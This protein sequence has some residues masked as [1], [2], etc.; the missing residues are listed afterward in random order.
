MR[1]ARVCDALLRHRSAVIVGLALFVLAG[2]LGAM[3]LPVDMSFRPTFTGD[4]R[5]VQRTREHEQVFGQ[6]GF[7]DLVALVDVKDA[8]DPVALSR[9][10]E[11]AERLRHVPRVVDVRDPLDFPYFDGHG[12]LH[13][14]GVTGSLALGFSLDSR[15]G[16]AAIAD[17]RRSPAARRMVL[18]D[19]DRRI[20]VTAAIDI[21]NE[22]FAERRATVLAFR[23]AVRDWSRRTGYPTQVTG[24]PEVEQVYAREV[25]LS[26][27]RSIATLLAILVAILFVYFRRWSDVLT[28]LLGVTV[29]VPLVLGTMAALGQPFSIVNSQVLTL[30]LI[31]GI[32]Q[33]L[34]HQEEYRRRRE[35]GREH[36]AANR[37]AFGLLAW[38]SF[39]TGFATIA[40]FASLLS[41]DMRAIWSFGLSTALGV[42][43]V[44]AVNW[45]VVPLLIERFYAAST[46]EQFH[47]ERTGGTLAIVRGITTL[48]ERSPGCSW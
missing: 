12:A 5:Q 33:A 47:S 1:A 37:E 29:S 27:F 14:N 10:A 16:R 26:V 11:L 43:I 15:F 45:L 39:M 23:Q 22:A 3:A 8:T 18:G 19:G 38:P 32:G 44:Y 21:P 46:T 28:C 2:L 24:Y 31:V 34:H 6:V 40:G 36:R 35:A 17:L 7:R 13:P 4:A 48:V 9:V 42:A 25:L 20:A 41:A 30:V